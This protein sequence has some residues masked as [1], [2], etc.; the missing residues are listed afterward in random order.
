MPELMPFDDRG[1][2]RMVDTSAKPETL[3]EARASGL[4]RMAPAGLALIRD[5]GHVKGEVLEV[6]CLAGQVERPT[7]RQTNDTKCKC[8][9]QEAAFASAGRPSRAE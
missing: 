6:A 2:C 4:V 5:K 8:G 9:C 7:G 1:A 3:R